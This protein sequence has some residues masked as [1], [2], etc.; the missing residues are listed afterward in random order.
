MKDMGSPLNQLYANLSLLILF[1]KIFFD[2]I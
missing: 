2:L 1:D